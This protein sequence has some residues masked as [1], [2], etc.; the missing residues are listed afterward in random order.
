MKRLLPFIYVFLCFISLL[1][2][3]CSTS[4]IEKGDVA[5]TGKDGQ[6]YGGALRVNENEMVQTLYP[7]SI[8]DRVSGHIGT[9]IYEGL[10]QFNPRDLSIVPAL[11]EKWAIDSSGMIYTFHLK[12]GV[13]FHDDECFTG[14]KGREL[15]ASDVKYSFELI[16]TPAPENLAY[17]TTLK[18]N[19]KGATAFY[20]SNGKMPLDGIVILDDYTVQFNLERPNLNFLSILT[21]LKT[22]IV[23]Q[24]GIKKYGTKLTIGTGPFIYAKKPQAKDKVILLKNPTYHKLDED[25]NQLP[26]MDSIIFTF[27]ET[28]K[29]ELEAF[30]E[31]KLD[32]I[33]GLPAESI[34]DVVEKQIAD[35]QNKPPKYI[36][37]RSPELVTQFYEFNTTLDIFKNKK[38]RQAIAYAIDRQR[39]IDN[40][41][42]GEAYGPAIYGITPPTIKNYDVTTIKGYTFDPEKAKKLL[43]E[44]GYPNGKNFPPVK[45]QLNSGGFRHTN[46]ALEVQKQLRS[47]LNINLDMEVIPFSEK[48]ENAKYAKSDIS[49]SAWLADYP[50]PENFLLLLYGKNVPKSVNEPSFPNTTRYQNPEFDRLF[51][52]GIRSLN[53]KEK[54]DYFKKAEQIAMDD[55]PLI[56]LWYD[57]KYR[58]YQATVNNFYSNPINYWNFSEVY[59]KPLPVKKDA[60]AKKE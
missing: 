10:V 39:I 2:S 42:K 26:Y 57:E 28:K 51:E 30:R 12:K 20:N 54:Y 11:A 25:G 31:G 47:V 19:L 23:P 14:G 38:V 34:K 4:N 13:R 15:K 44:A 58:L 46:V 16:C 50:D 60:S 40:I 27:I 36:L 29:A 5:Q 41:L 6:V 3:S 7:L 21:D 33:S 24:E 1:L 43:A 59:L 53:T 37:D 8:V 48:I 17:N 52:A 18:D 56:P 55:A 32:I 49:R 22:S 35:F 45:L 9:Q